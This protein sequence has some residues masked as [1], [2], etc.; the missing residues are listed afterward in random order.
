MLRFMIHIMGDLHQPVYAAEGFFNDTRLGDLP[1][2]DLGANKFKLEGGFKNLH[3]LWDAV[4]GLYPEEWPLSR[5]QQARLVE[6]ATELLQEFPREALSEYTPADAACFR[7][8]LAGC[9]DVFERWASETHAVAAREA[10]GHGIVY[11]GTP[12]PEYLANMVK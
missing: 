4:G 9:G 10:Y 11:G 2:G 3:L 7:S 8:D 5:A 1:G 12:S 6:N